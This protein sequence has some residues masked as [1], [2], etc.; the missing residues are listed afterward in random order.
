MYVYVEASINRREEEMIRWNISPR[1]Y[2]YP[3][4]LRELFFCASQELSIRAEGGSVNLGK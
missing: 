1:D 4:Y 3:E 2:L